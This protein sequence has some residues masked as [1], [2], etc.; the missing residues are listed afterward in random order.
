MTAPKHTAAR[1]EVE[2]DGMGGMWVTGPDRN[3]PVVCDI[4][5][6]SHY[7]ENGNPILTEEDEANAKLIAAAPE[8]FEALTAVMRLADAHDDRGPRLLPESEWRQAKAALEKAR[9]VP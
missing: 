6:R 2:E 4:V 3:A 5:A 8:L 7:S 9:G 1:W